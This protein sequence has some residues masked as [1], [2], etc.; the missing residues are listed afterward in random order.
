MDDNGTNSISVLFDPGSQ[1]DGGATKKS[2]IH[3]ENVGSSIK[4]VV[5]SEGVLGSRGQNGSE[6]RDGL[7]PGD[8]E[9]W[10]AGG[11]CVARQ[12]LC[13]GVD[14]WKGRNATVTC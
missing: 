11:V 13:G 4:S 12:D 6:Y 5:D 8:S 2:R 9:G 10:G 3:P 1:W 7:D 14:N